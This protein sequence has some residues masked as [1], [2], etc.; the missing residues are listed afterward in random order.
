MSCPTTRRL[1]LSPISCSIGWSIGSISPATLS[2][3]HRS[4]KAWS[5]NLGS[6][7]QTDLSKKYSYLNWCVPAR[8]LEQAWC[9]CAYRQKSPLLHVLHLMHALR[10]LHVP[11]LMHT[12]HQ[13]HVLHLMHELHRRDPHLLPLQLGTMGAP[14]LSPRT[15]RWSCP[16]D[17]P[18]KRSSWPTTAPLS[19]ED[20]YKFSASDMVSCWQFNANWLWN[21]RFKC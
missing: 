10:L 11:H 9:V 16:C 17:S 5:L 14:T 18:P 6:C 3:S 2:S 4:P 8:K 21:L 15:K 19:S 12:F 1:E 13:L 7:L 20:R